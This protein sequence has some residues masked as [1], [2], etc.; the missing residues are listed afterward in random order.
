MPDLIEEQ[1]SQGLSVQRL[2]EV[3]RRRRMLFLFPLF[4]GWLLVWGSSWVLPPR[5]QSSTLIMV[6]EPTMPQNY[7][8]PNVTDDLQARVQSIKTQLLSK[9]RLLIIIDRLHL[10]SGIEDPSTADARVEQMRKDID[11]VLDRDPQKQD[12]TAFRISFSSKNPQ[13]AQSV[14]GELANVFI[15]EN[16]K[17]RQQESEGTTTFFEKQVEEA[18]QN[19]AEQEAKVRQFEAMHEGTL[20]TQQSGNL[21]I[22]GGLQ[23]QLQN[24]EEGLTNA[25]QQRVYLEALLEQQKAALSKARTINGAGGASAPADLQTVN[26][27]LERLQSQLDDLSVRYTDQYPDVVSLKHQI[28]KLEAIRANLLAAA[29]TRSK[30]PKPST[31]NSDSAADLDPTLSAP[32]Q[33][34]QSQLQANQVEITNRENAIN[35]FKARINDYQGRLNTEPST[36]QQLADLTRGYDQS[37]QNYDELLKKKDDSEMATSM[38]TM[39]QGERFTMLDPPDL[40]L[41]PD[42]PNRLKFCGIGVAVGLALGFLVAGGFEL[43]DDRLHTEKEIKALLPISV[44]SEVPEVVNDFDKQKTKRHAVLGWAT[45]AFVL[46]A[47]LAGSVFSFLNN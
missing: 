17:V 24:E 11:V 27:Q 23:S 4:F 13:I 25:K 30:S 34:T 21:E 39:Q 29:K 5:Y 9:T 22:L 16:N 36:E 15:G 19:L 1:E 42:F 32:A 35:A 33:Q 38:E 14:T 31:D 46:V 26:A 41:K 7:V 18:R 10:Y 43:M 2:L 20:P 3:F 44:L 40:P 28:A 45:T 12:V 47:I 8:Q 37:K 6:E